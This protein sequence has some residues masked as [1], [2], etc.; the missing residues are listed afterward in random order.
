MR[1]SN[2]IAF[3]INFQCSNY[4]ENVQ[5]YIYNV[6]TKTRAK[7]WQNNFSLC[8]SGKMTRGNAMAIMRYN[9]LDVVA[10]K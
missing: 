4:I 5:K 1:C 8:I 3:Y 10:E 7:N 2:E 6:L 9:I